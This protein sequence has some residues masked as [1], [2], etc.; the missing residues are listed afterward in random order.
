MRK[1]IYVFLVLILFTSCSNK[2]SVSKLNKPAKDNFKNELQ[3]ELVLNEEY[4][5]GFPERKKEIE[6]NEKFFFENRIKIRNKVIDSLNVLQNDNVIIIDRVGDYNGQRKEA[7]YLFFDKKIISAS[8]DIVEDNSKG[9]SY[10]KEI[11]VIEET[12]YQ[13]LNDTHETDIL[14]IYNFFNN[15]DLKNNESTF[16]CSTAVTKSYY[17]T[18]VLNK[19]VSYYFLKRDGKCNVSKLN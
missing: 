14:E 15:R 4:I 7:S 10:F 18:V 17:I 1:V 16:D 3:K 2:I 6:E 19:K 5:K 13:S 12:S 11:P 9:D 8:H